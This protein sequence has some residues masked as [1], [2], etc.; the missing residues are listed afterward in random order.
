M[1]FRSAGNLKVDASKGQFKKLE[2]GVGRLLGVLSLQ[3]L[4]RRI[5]LDFRDIFSDGFAFDSITGS[6]QINRG[7]MKTEELNIRGPAARVLLAGQV[8]LI[9]ETQDLTVRVQPAVGESIAV[10]AMIVNPVVGAVAW[11]AQKVLGDPLDRAF[12]FEYAVSG[13]WS[14]PKVERISHSPPVENRQP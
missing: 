4:P 7:L 3:S 5:T 11:A 9:E 1:L 13:P 12:A 2:P 8:N 14:D 10:G 6:A